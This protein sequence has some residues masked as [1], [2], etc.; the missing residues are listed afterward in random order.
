MG[1]YGVRSDN[2]TVARTAPDLTR[3]MAAL[4]AAGFRRY[5]TYRQATAAS[6][7]T[8]SVFGFL[9]C[10]ILLAAVAAAGPVIGGY[11]APRLALYCWASQGLIGVIAL[12]GWTDLGDRIRSGDVVGDL[13]RPVHPIL[14]YLGPDLGRAGHAVLTR[15]AFPILLGAVFFDLYVPHS[16]ATYP[17]FILSVLLGVVV[18]FGCRYLVNAAAFWLLDVRGVNLLSQLGSSLF[19]GLAFPLHF[20]PSWLT[21]TIWV[22]T[23][24]PSVLQA[25]LDVLVE[26]GSWTVRL[27]EVGGQAA[28]AVVMLA[29]CVYV[30]RRAERK[31]VIQ[32]G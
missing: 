31:M 25:P 12:W 26:R 11:D 10:Y 13:L 22:A 32:G 27:A 20:L 28:W 29:L 6:T 17:L 4:A 30:Q 18:S 5:S 23:P 8:N 3:T 19:A 15:F 1:G 21:W 7:F 2:A 9:R 16:P 14:T 24:F